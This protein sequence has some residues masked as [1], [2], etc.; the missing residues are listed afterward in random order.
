MPQKYQWLLKINPMTVFILQY[1]KI[2]F[3]NVVPSFK[4]LG[5]LTAL[6]LFTLYLAIKIFDAYK[7]T[8]AE[9]V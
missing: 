1:Q 5:Y 9:E 8:F 7:E 6:S 4:A 3:W 2:L